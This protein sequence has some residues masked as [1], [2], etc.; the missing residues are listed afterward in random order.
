[1]KRI[2]LRKTLLISLAFLFTLCIAAFGISLVPETARAVSS[3]AEKTVKATQAYAVNAVGT[4][5]AFTSNPESTTMKSLKSA[6][7]FT[8]FTEAIKNSPDM[9]FNF[10]ES[11]NADDY[12]FLTFKAYFW[13][14]NYAKN[15]PVTVTN[16]DGD[17]TTTTGIWGQQTPNVEEAKLWVTVSTEKIKNADGKVAGF[18][19]TAPAFTDEMPWF[20][21]S[22]FT[23]TNEARIGIDYEK[24]HGSQGTGDKIVIQQESWS[25]PEWKTEALRNRVTYPDIEADFSVTVK[26]LTPIPATDVDNFKIRG[27]YGKVGDEG[28]LD[29]YQYLSG[30]TYPSGNYVLGSGGLTNGAVDRGMPNTNLTWYESTTANIGFEASILQGLINAEF[31]YFI[32]KRDGL[33]ATRVLTLPTTFGQS[34]PQENLNSDK[35]Q[36]FEIVL[37]HRNT[38]GDFTYDIKGNFSTTRN[39]NR[40]VERAASA[41]MYDNWR[42][43]SNDRYKDIQWGKVCIGQFS[44]YEEILNSPIQDG[45]GNFFLKLSCDIY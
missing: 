44:S 15:A 10:S 4:H 16:L 43:N 45:N 13:A 2:G 22:D 3:S 42:N 19:M 12:A 40:H 30:Y 29:A 31:D 28:D 25:I 41:N 5:T 34:L 18:K 9:V 8:L 23:F 39:Y 26:F 6:F 7:N 27:S 17:K 38:I 24:S 1:M 32:R 33:L 36:G 11:V 37:G 14:N 21:I 35:T 20:M